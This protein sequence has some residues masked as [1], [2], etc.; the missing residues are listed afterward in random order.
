[1]LNLR[2]LFD[3]NM[4]KSDDEEIAR[5]TVFLFSAGYRFTLK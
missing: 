4:L 3:F 1:M 2:Y 5:R